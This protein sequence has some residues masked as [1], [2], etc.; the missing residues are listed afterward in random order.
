MNDNEFRLT[1]ADVRGQEFRRA[2]LGYDITSVEEFRGRIAEELERLFRERAALEERLS[3]FREQL[4]A[5]REREKALNDA[6]VMAHQV[7]ADVEDAAKR[8]SELAMREARSKADDILGDARS[9]EI[10]IRRDIEEAQRQ[11]GAYLAAFRRLLERQLAQLD[12]LADHE[13]DGSMPGL[14]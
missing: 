3:S 1:P 10:S 5:F 7:R 2:A 8:E 6:V 13:R 12:A 9:V 11:F 4:K 14:K